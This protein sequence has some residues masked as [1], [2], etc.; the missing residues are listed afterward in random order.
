M[1]LPSFVRAAL[2][3]VGEGWCDRKGS[4]EVTYAMMGS[5]SSFHDDGTRRAQ[6]VG[7]RNDRRS[8]WL[9]SDA[10]Q[11][12]EGRKWQKPLSA[13]DRGNTPRSL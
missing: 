1:P 2:L 3:L 5:D 12:Y 13:T 11:R 4:H 7:S 8:R 10:N 6:Q 9:V